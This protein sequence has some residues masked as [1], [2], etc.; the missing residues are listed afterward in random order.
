MGLSDF[1]GSGSDGQLEPI[2]LVAGEFWI[3]DSSR[4]SDCFGRTLFVLLFLRLLQ[5]EKTGHE[6][7]NKENVELVR[8]LT[9]I[10]KKMLNKK[11]EEW[12]SLVLL[13]TGREV[14][15]I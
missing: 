11:K 2:R 10:L 14:T 4:S 5:W 6:G 15:C 3:T 12:G 7:E 1:E 13:P 9:R 8:D